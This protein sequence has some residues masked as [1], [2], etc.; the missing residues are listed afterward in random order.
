MSAITK[1]T[2]FLKDIAPVGGK[3]RTADVGKIADVLFLSLEIF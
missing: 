2:V 3:N 1:C